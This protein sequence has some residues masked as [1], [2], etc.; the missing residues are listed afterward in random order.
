MQVNLLEIM[1]I[2]GVDF[3]D[4]FKWY[5]WDIQTLGIEAARTVLMSEIREVIML[6]IMLTLT[7]IIVMILDKSAVL[8]QL[9]VL[10]LIVEYCIGKCSFE[11]TKT[12]QGIN[13]GEVDHLTGVHLILWWVKYHQRV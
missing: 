1:T 12:I 10:V 2:P 9:M 11:E 3:W 4:L 7:F 13:F 6:V 8:C 5:I